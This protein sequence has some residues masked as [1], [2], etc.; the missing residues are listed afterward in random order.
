M[1]KEMIIY[2]FIFFMAFSSILF[3]FCFS[4]NSLV[5][6]LLSPARQFSKEAVSL[7]PYGN[8]QISINKVLVRI[9]YCQP[10]GGSGTIIEDWKGV[11]SNTVGEVSEFYRLQFNY[12]ME[13]NFEIYPQI[14]YLSHSSEYFA[15]LIIEDFIRELIEE[16]SECQSLRAISSGV[17]NEIKD[18]KE[19]KLSDKRVDDFYVVNLFV[20]GLDINTLQ[21]KGTKILGLNDESNN[22]LVFSTGFING[23]L[24][25]F[26]G[27]IVSH[28]IGHSLGV[29]RFYSYSGDAVKSSGIMGGGLTRK[30]RDN[31]LKYQIKEEMTD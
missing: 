8:E 24:K 31:Y 28:E 13:M 4:S 6:N 29:P 17:E 10:Q 9:Y 20:L 5:F 25:D 3:L 7:Y 22:A 1:T 19:W 15:G 30:L 14:V 11:L 26:Y 12:N 16:H 21:T 27:S 2:L 23:E 18:D